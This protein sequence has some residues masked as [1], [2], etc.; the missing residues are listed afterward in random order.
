MRYH[1]PSYV[2]K[3]Q[4]N[5]GNFSN[6]YLPLHLKYVEPRSSLRGAPHVDGL[7]YFWTRIVCDFCSRELT[8]KDDRLA[9]LAGIATLISQKTGYRY[10]AGIWDRGTSGMGITMMELLWHAISPG[11]YLQRPRIRRAPS[12]SWVSIDHSIGSFEDTDSEDIVMTAVVSFRMVAEFPAAQSEG[13]LIV[14]KGKVLKLDSMNEMNTLSIKSRQE[15]IECFPD[16][17]DAPSGNIYCLSLFNACR[18][19]DIWGLLLGRLGDEKY[20]RCSFFRVQSFVEG[21]IWKAFDL[22]QPSTVEII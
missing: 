9:A 4:L 5:T 17:Y 14:T 22:A 12:W 7:W 1:V 13:T 19:G 20:E 10:L 11:A 21:K 15:L 16:Y 18:L 8:V 3:R 2:H 6:D